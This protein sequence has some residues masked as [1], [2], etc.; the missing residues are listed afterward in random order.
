MEDLKFAAYLGI[1]LVPALVLHE[2]AHAFVAVRLGDPTPKRW[3]RLTLNPK[4]LIDPFGS[5][6]LP[7]L[8]LIL[9]AARG[10]LLL[11]VF[12][13]AKP[14]PVDPSYLKNPRRDQAYVVLA[15]LLA[16]ITLAIAGGLVIRAGVTGELGTFAL[17]W[18]IVNAY[19]FG[20]QL[21]PV[22]GFDGA[23]LLAPFLPPR[24]REVFVN[25]EQYLVLFVLVIFFILAGPLLSIVNAFANV[26]CN[27]AAGA[28]CF[29]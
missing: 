29:G 4:P 6:I 2:Y 5:L 25:L 9:V 8:A 19:M 17:A 15:G 16:N 21:M 23:K 7:A 27:L 11:P 28:D 22:P 12:A 13:Y 26:A 18:L 10:E 20:F 3:G 24:P 14:M 1:S